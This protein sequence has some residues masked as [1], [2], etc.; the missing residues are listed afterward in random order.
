MLL[1]ATITISPFQ[2]TCPRSMIMATGSLRT[3]QKR[4]G[5]VTGSCRK[6]LEITG[7]GS[8]IPTGTYR[9]FFRW[10]PVN[11]LSFPA[12]IGG[13]TASTFQRFPVFSCWNRPVFFDL[14]YGMQ[15]TWKVSA[16]KKNTKINKIGT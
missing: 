15:K 14:G 6:A 1:Q 12:G 2:H 5:K 10:I 11:F 7:S 13:Y 4:H 16:R 3:L 9:I 8:S